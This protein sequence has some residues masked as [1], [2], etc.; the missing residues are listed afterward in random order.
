M[1]IHG[2]FFGL[3][4]I[5]TLEQEKAILKLSAKYIYHFQQK[6]CGVKQNNEFFSVY[7]ENCGNISTY[8]CAV[9]YIAMDFVS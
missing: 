3:F 8:L 5:N 2:R 9:P 7:P 4:I 6:F 1:I